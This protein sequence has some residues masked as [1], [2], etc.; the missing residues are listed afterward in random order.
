[1]NESNRDLNKMDK[2]EEIEEK[3]H[4]PC[5]GIEN[6]DHVINESKKQLKNQDGFDKVKKKLSEIKT[7]L[8]LKETQNDHKIRTIEKRE[9]L[10]NK[11]KKK[12]IKKTCNMEEVCCKKLRKNNLPIKETENSGR[13]KESLANSQIN[14]ECSVQNEDLK[15]ISS[16]QKHDLDSEEEKSY[17]DLSFTEM[18]DKVL[19]CKEKN[20]NKILKNMHSFAQKPEPLQLNKATCFNEDE[21]IFRKTDIF[22]KINEVNF[23]KE[24]VAD[25]KIFKTKSLENQCFVKN[26][27]N[28]DTIDQKLFSQSKEKC[29]Q[30]KQNSSSL[31]L[32]FKTICDR[33]IEDCNSK[34]FNVTPLNDNNNN[35]KIKKNLHHLDDNGVHGNNSSCP[36]NCRKKNC[37][38]HCTYTPKESDELIVESYSES[39]K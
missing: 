10:N 15:K 7:E 14:Q 37:L 25:N 36:K 24:K 27:T 8:K 18:R 23:P 9:D 4:E 34:I 26:C 21:K 20:Q 16:I 11:N 1:M 5:D 3:L 28:F 32:H 13:L 38:E 19:I 39:D 6:I 31:N 12:Q 33:G 35:Q 22:K 17:Q 30:E 29:M 2:T